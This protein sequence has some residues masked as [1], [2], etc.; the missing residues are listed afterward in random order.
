MF[1]QLTPHCWPSVSIS[2]FPY[3]EKPLQ[4]VDGTFGNNVTPSTSERADTTG[5]SLDFGPFSSGGL[6]VFFYH[7][8]RSPTPPPLSSIHL[9]IIRTSVGEG[10]L[11]F[12]FFFFFSFYK[13]RDKKM[14]VKEKEKLYVHKRK[15][16]RT[17]K[18]TLP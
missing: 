1:Q 11:F 2:L 18:T 5:G 6:F 9:P 16:N 15:E 4:H 13:K 17:R 12:F 8:T 7:Y 14:I 3:R 10:I